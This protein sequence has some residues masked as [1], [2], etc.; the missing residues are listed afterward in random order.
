MY[1]VIRTGGRQAKVEEGQRVQVDLLQEADGA[2][3]TLTPLMVVDG[4]DVL[5]GAAQLGEA[6]VSARV[7]GEVKG[8]KIVGFTY[9][10]KTNQ[11]KRWGHRQRYTE[12]E[13]TGIS[14]G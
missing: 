8:P 3:L 1:A 4:D 14:R 7:I 13:I 6:T 2:E 11:R 9:K 12:I 10:N 5:A